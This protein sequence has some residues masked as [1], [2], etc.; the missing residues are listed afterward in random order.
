M[1]ETQLRE[2]AGNKV[3]DSDIRHFFETDF[4]VVG[5]FTPNYE[6][7]A[8]AFAQNLAEHRISHHLYA[9][10]IVEG[11]WYSQTRQKPTVLAH[12]RRDHPDKN[13]VFMDVDCRIRGDISE[14]L[15][16]RGDVV[17]R[18]KGTAK[19][20]QRALKPTTRVMLLR[21]TPGSDAFITGWEAACRS[22]RPGQSAE[23]MLI[24]AMSDS[25]EI[26]SI[27]TLPIRLAG[28]ELHDAL[29]DAVIVH[30][31]I[32]DP[33]RPGWALRRGLQRYFRV[34]RNAAY[35]LAT[36]KTYDELKGKRRGGQKIQ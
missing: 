32:R 21:P 30:D 35:R 27:G 36:G 22:A 23:F 10:P 14:I 16:T 9:R 4:L 7:A 11:D 34:A 13:L 2:R 28:I 12:A 17:M 1:I 31:S 8:R 3:E 5:F 6:P 18:T 26:Y 15:N 20:T 33:T 19:G 24:H 29:P 25:S